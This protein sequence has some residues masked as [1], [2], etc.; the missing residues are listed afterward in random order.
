MPKLHDAG[1]KTVL[2]KSGNF[3]DAALVDLI[4]AQPVSPRFIAAR[5]WNRFG[6]SGGVALRLSFFQAPSWALR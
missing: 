1:S 5:A 3:D 6:A 4:L 2:G